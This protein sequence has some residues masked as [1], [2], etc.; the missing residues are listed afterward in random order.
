MATVPI[1]FKDILLLRLAPTMSRKPPLN[2]ASGSA[3][4]QRSSTAYA[5]IGHRSVAPAPW[6]RCPGHRR[7]DRRHYPVSGTA[8][9]DYAYPAGRGPSCE[10]EADEFIHRPRL[11]RL[12]HQAGDTI[13]AVMDSGLSVL[14]MQ[15]API[16]QAAYDAVSPGV[17]VGDELGHGTQMTLIASREQSIP[18]GAG[19]STPPQAAQWL[20]SVHLTTTDL[21]PITR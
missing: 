13:V 21:L 20:P 16:V 2:G 5:A 1:T 3:G 17:E 10:T 19:T 11:R 6:Q 9:P 15:T 4:R 12:R 14:I 8:E 7:H 18:L